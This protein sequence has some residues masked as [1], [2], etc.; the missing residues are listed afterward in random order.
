MW[1]PF[2]KKIKQN[3]CNFNFPYIQKA[4]AEKDIE[5][6]NMNTLGDSYGFF[7][8]KKENVAPLLYLSTKMALGIEQLR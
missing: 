6:M 8:V 2:R 5:L 1:N 7:I 4:L 3:R